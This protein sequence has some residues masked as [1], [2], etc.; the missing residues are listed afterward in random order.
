M[1]ISIATALG[2]TTLIA[3]GLLYGAQVFEDFRDA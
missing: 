2:V 1:L 3:T